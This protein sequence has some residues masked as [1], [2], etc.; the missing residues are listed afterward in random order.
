MNNIPILK[1]VCQWSRFNSIFLIQTINNNI[2]KTILI[3]GAISNP[4]TPK[5]LAK[6]LGICQPG[7]YMIAISIKKQKLH[8]TANLDKKGTY[9]L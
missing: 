7:I 4:K 2:P 8:K 9:A 5:K 1:K 6:K 3:N